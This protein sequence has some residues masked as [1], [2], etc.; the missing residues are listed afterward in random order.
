MSV[1]A[2]SRPL[3]PHELSMSNY[4]FAPP[5]MGVPNDKKSVFVLY[6][7]LSPADVVKIT[8]SWMSIIDIGA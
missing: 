3:M 7:P 2:E 4:S 1:G 8:S 5:N 6:V